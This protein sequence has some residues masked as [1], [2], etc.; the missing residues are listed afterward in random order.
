MSIELLQTMEWSRL[1]WDQSFEKVID[2]ERI[3][4]KKGEIYPVNLTENE[5]YAKEGCVYFLWQPPHSEL[6]GW[7]DKR[8]SEILRSYVLKGNLKHSETHGVQFDFQVL[9]RIEL[10]EVFDQ[11]DEDQNS[12]L[13]YIGKSAGESTLQWNDARG[14]IKY[15]VGKFIFLSGTE[16]ESSLEAILSY[17]SEKL[18]LHYSATLHSP[19]TYETVVTKYYPSPKEIITFQ[20]LIDDA[21]EM[22]DESIES[23]QGNQIFG[24]EYW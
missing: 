14:I 16:C 24:A 23:L 17:D 8:P 3:L 15:S 20:R 11:V 9:N 12:P 13:S 22:V 5:D 6:N 2:I 19:A 21:V 7:G 10:L 4:P 1:C 18:C